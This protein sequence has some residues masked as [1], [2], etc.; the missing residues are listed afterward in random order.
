MHA[1]DTTQRRALCVDLPLELEQARQMGLRLT[2]RADRMLDVRD[3]GRTVA[4]VD[5]HR[6]VVHTH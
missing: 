2:L 1:L 5:T 3:G 6:F 4:T